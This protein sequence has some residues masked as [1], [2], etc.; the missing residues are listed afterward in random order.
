MRA[1]KRIDGGAYTQAKKHTSYERH[2][3]LKRKATHHRGQGHLK[4]LD[5]TLGLPLH[6]EGSGVAGVLVRSGGGSLGICA[7]RRRGK[8]G[9]LASLLKRGDLGRK[10]EFGADVVGEPGAKVLDR[11][12]LQGARG[13]KAEAKRATQQSRASASP[14]PSSRSRREPHS[15]QH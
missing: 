12:G 11:R 9:I 8:R 2:T 10:L 15:P 6:S 7:K 3:T 5:R 4:L 1:G 13:V 14:P